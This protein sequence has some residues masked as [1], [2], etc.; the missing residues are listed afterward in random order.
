M[1][2]H[3]HNQDFVATVDADYSRGAYEIDQFQSS[4]YD[5]DDLSCIDPELRSLQHD[6]PYLRL[7]DQ[8]QIDTRRCFSSYNPTAQGFNQSY[9]CDYGSTLYQLNLS[10]TWTGDID[11]YRQIRYLSPST[12][13]LSS[14]ESSVSDY[15]FTPDAVRT[16]QEFSFTFESP[17]STHASLGM[18]AAS[19]H[20]WTHH[21]PG[22]LPTMTTPTGNLAL[23]M[24]DLQVTP[25]PKIEDDLVDDKDTIHG[26][27]NLP[28]ELELSEQFVSPPASTLASSIDDDASMQDA[29]EFSGAYDSDNNSEFIPTSAS[30]RRGLAN[31]RQSLRS[32]RQ[33]APKAIIDPRSRVHKNTQNNTATVGPSRPKAKKVPRKKKN[34]GSK[35]FPCTF[36]HY[37]CGGTFAS[38]NEWKRHVS[39]QHLQLGFFRCDMGSCSPQIARTQHKG[40]N[41]FNRKD[42]FTQ[43]CRRMHAPWVGTTHGEEGVTKKEKDAFEKELDAIR[44]RCW[45]DSRKAPERSKCGF[46][47]KKF[48][49][50]QV[51]DGVVSVSAWDKRME[52]VGRHF[53]RDA[54]RAKDEDVDE[55]LKA[56]ALTQGVVRAGRRKG[57]FWL[58]GLEPVERPGTPPGRRRSG[59]VAERR[60][61]ME[62]AE[63]EESS[64]EADSMEVK[65]TSTP[66]KTEEEADKD[67]ESGED[68]DE[69]DA[70]AD[71]DDDADADAESDE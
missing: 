34:N 62:E 70:D 6:Y 50:G 18:P 40:F 2:P 36:H 24:R 45:V 29:E 60:E 66:T 28:E 1:H 13:T 4:W 54:A 19:Q 46:C 44:A 10:G 7:H 20:L 39:S 31:S 38:K 37:G 65:H 16:T 25:D 64:S 71:A 30:V 53:E 49:E 32:P 33:H 14:T 61:M 57:E 51:E 67:S 55:G 23:S 59:R 56:W 69:Q 47:G 9:R 41:D 5:R 12:N 15:A 35:F 26:K 8:Q 27:I 21:S 42:L 68:E 17:V 48:V 52:H 43:H 3:I 63:E 58:A 22:V 11:E